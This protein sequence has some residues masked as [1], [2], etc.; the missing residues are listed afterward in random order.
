MQKGKANFGNK[1][2]VIFQGRKG[3]TVRQ[4]LGNNEL[5]KKEHG[6]LSFQLLTSW[7]ESWGMKPQRGKGWLDQAVS[8]G[9]T[10]NMA[11]GSRAADLYLV[12]LIHFLFH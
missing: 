7:M 3:N 11:Q 2:G 9:I 4:R 1:G 12:T 10:G 6:E 8:V 5:E